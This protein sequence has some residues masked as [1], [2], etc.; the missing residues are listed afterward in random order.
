MILKLFYALLLSIP[1]TIINFSAYLKGNTPSTMNLVSTILF[2]I[3]WTSWGGFK[4]Y[5]DKLSIHFLKFSSIYCL[6]SIACVFVMYLID[7][8]LFSIPVGIIILGPV[9]GLRYFLPSVSYETFG[10]ICVII[11]YAASLIGSFIGYVT[12][13]KQHESKQ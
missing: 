4:N 6:V 7:S 3:L 13:K 2:L 9:Y 11:V 1:F 5:R 8:I 10:Y 12:S